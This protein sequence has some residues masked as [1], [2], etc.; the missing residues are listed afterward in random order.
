MLNHAGNSYIIAQKQ[1]CHLPDTVMSQTGDGY[2]T[3]SRICSVCLSGSRSNDTNDTVAKQSKRR[4]WILKQNEESKSS[5]SHFI[6]LCFY[7]KMSHYIYNMVSRATVR[8]HILCNTAPWRIMST[9]AFGIEWHN[10]QG[11]CV[12]SGIIFW[13]VTLE[14]KWFM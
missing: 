8:E 6:W 4:S 13:Y 5:V 12:T 7:L 2:I 3:L 10:S 9:S 14:A 1:L 11:F